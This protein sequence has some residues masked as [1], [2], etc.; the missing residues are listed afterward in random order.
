[1]RRVLVLHGPNLNL[2][3]NREPSIYGKTSLDAIDA[4]LAELGD[5]LGIQ[6]DIR[7]SNLEGELVT[8]IQEA[9]T[10]YDGI[11]INPAAYTHT[12]VAIR[13]ALAAVDLPTIEVH[14]SN[15]HRREE[16]RRHS[17]ISGVA[18]AQISGFGPTGY[19]LALRG[20]HEHLASNGTK[21]AARS[22]PAARTRAGKQ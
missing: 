3:G 17:Y 15:I 9:R 14:L 12:S 5:E 19:L 4:A 10:G 1:M 20:L 18:L 2:L 13:D 8:W 16:F 6:L 22:R 21:P 7:Q 11:V